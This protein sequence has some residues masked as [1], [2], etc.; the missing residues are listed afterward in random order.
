M[1]KR[2]RSRDPWWH[3]RWGDVGR[4]VLAVL[5]AAIGLGIASLVV[6]EFNIGG[7]ARALA[8]AVLIA[9][10]GAVL[11]PVLVRLAVLL[12]W[13]GAVVVGLA[14]QAFIIWL[15]LW[16]FTGKTDN[17]PFWSVFLAS[18]VVS[19][20]STAF[21][22][23]ATAGTDDAVTAGLLRKG[24]RSRQPALEDADLPGV[25]FIQTDG[26]PFPVLDWG[27]RAGTLPTL[28]RWIRSGTHHMAE[29]RPKLPAT[30]PASQMGIL[31]GTIDGIPAFRWV[32]R[33]TGRVLVANKP[34]DAAVI[35]AMH[36]DGRGL[37]ADD[38]VS[39]SN[40]FTGDAPTAYAT[41]SAVQRT[42]ETRHARYTVSTFLARPEGLARSLSRTVSEIV[43][44]RFQAARARRRDVHPR[45][46]R[47]WAFAFERAALCGVLR[48]LNTTLVAD[49]M[50]QGHRSIYVDFVDYDAV[51]HHAGLMQPES[52]A[53]LEGIDAVIGQLER[54]AAVAPRPYL[55][56]ILSDHGQSQGEVF[57]S[58]YGEDLATLVRRL[59]SSDVLSAQ[60]NA[61]GTGS[62]ASMMASTGDTDTVLGRS[63][64]RASDRL[65]AHR[66]EMPAP[67]STG[68]EAEAAADKCLVF[69]SGNLGLVYVAGEHA[70]L[71][72]DQLTERFPGLVPGLVS[73][74]GAG[75]VVVDTA[76]HGPV[77]LG[78][79][80]EHR[81]RE[82]VV[83]GT[84]PLAAYGPDAAAFVLRAST[85]DEAPDIYVNSLVDDLGEVAA[86]EGLVGCHGGLG[87]WQDRAVVM[88]PDALPPPESMVVGADAMHR[89]LVGWLEHLGH[90]SS[91]APV[92]AGAAPSGGA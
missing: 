81:L 57:A 26:V 42:Q 79:A 76:D 15:V 48:D 31:H 59:T 6:P 12:G 19:A 50:L 36:S 4:A 77:V 35:E 22:W 18:W 54:V 67:A 2:D 88:W 14:G 90:R 5:G 68:E 34:A 82:G 80:G 62:L 78:A 17:P 69:G 66:L 29:W 56:V 1:T 41:M 89:L 33:D 91:L 83:V 45:V 8:A 32:E 53:A 73:H 65:S 72:L 25:V 47:P 74:P 27:V 13:V 43:R 7:A 11:R 49:A 39:V 16:D 20:V 51:A 9:V 70:R 44:E 28:S 63:L 46:D 30:T 55:F 86:F 10:V 92:A 60:E 71:N 24:R 21:V 64:R 58:R 61:E 85:M 23:V 84:D 38:G 3:L 87:G 75:F 52:L 37:L 40:L